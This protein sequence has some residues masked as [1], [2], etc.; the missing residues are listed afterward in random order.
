[1]SS[2]LL[3]GILK[4]SKAEDVNPNQNMASKPER[5]KSSMISL[6]GQKVQINFK[7]LYNDLLTNQTRSKPK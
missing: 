5:L 3:N 1:L 2:H 7:S 4:D 6:N